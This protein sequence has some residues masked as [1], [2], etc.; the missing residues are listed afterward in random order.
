[1]SDEPKKTASDYVHSAMKG[2]LSAIPVAGGPLSIL[3][4]T[5]FSAPIDKRRQ[6]WLSSLGIAI[7]ELT[8]KVDGLSPEALSGNEAFIS[9][10]LQATQIALRNH[11]QEK[12]AALKNAIINTV[13]EKSIDENKALIFTR[14]IDE[15]TPLHIMVLTFLNKP[16]NY[17]KE[18]QAKARSTF[19]HY[20][21]NISVFEEYYPELKS[22]SSLVEQVI[23]ELY[24]K[25]FVFVESIHRGK[26]R[27]TT[28]FGQEFLAFISSTDKA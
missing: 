5:V 22:S 10:A 7:E 21:N 28:Q 1:M 4:E 2:A 16:E 17:E 12:I 8:K 18:L 24:A 3:F 19:T 25:G 11:Q 20:P 13:L 6:E 27:V 26:G 14:I 23:K 9:V 15:I